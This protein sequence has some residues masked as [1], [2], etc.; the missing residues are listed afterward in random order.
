MLYGP[1]GDQSVRQLEAGLASYRNYGPYAVDW[2][3]ACV[4]KRAQES[5][6]LQALGIWAQK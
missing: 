2:Y 1:G 5:A 3:K 6:R 4:Y